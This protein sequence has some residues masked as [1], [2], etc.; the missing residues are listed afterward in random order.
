MQSKD[1]Q[2]SSSAPQFKSI[3]SLA[4]RFLYGTNLTSEHD[5]WEN[6]SFDYTE[7]VSKVMSLLFN[8]LSVCVREI[9]SVLS[10]SL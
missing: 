8:M 6:H 5:Y 10:D 7:L 2:E 9:A 4:L 3:S 1:S